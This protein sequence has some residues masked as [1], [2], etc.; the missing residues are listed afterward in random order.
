[1]NYFNFYCSFL[2]MI[3]QPRQQRCRS[4]ETYNFGGPWV[5]IQAWTENMSVIFFCADFSTFSYLK[6]ASDS[7]GVVHKPCGL[8]KGRGRSCLAAYVIIQFDVPQQ[9]LEKQCLVYQ[10]IAVRQYH[11]FI[12]LMQPVKQLQLQQLRIHKLKNYFIRI[13]T[14]WK[15]CRS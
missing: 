11:T 10:S 15:K 2:H 6:L 5:R 4:A 1:M 14:C 13:Q 3:S 7:F 9:V 12:F 8:S